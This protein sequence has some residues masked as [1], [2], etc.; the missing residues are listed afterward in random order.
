LQWI[1]DRSE[2]RAQGV[3]TALGIMPRFEDLNW[4]GLEKVSKP[5]YEE[6]ADVDRAA[7]RDELASHDDLFGKLGRHLP[8]S[9][10]ARRGE[11]H[12]KLSA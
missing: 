9:L 10:E 2:G 11:M 12:E 1:V 5:R 3:P 8:S 7:W 6:L 4:S